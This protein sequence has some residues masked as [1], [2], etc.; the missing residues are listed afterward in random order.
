MEKALDYSVFADLYDFF[1]QD[2]FDVPF[3]LNE[4]GKTEGRVLE[5]MSGTGRVSLPLLKEGVALTCVDNSPDMLSFLEKKIEERGFSADVYEMDVCELALPGTYEFIIIPF[6]SFSEILTGSRQ[7]SALAKIYNHLSETGK[8]ICT[9]QNPV[10]RLKTVDGKLRLWREF[11]LKGGKG[12]LLLSGM[13]NY[14]PAEHIVSG[15]EFFELYDEQGV[16]QSKRCTDIKFYLHDRDGFESLVAPAGFQ[17]SELYGDYKYTAFDS[18][19]SP[20]MIYVLT[21]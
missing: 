18:E 10:E 3:F 20:F 1:V 11:P 6:H 5:L 2:D 16:L 13:L 7:K 12:R 8:F 15:L 19:T 9:L 17:I 4:A 21:K 14:N